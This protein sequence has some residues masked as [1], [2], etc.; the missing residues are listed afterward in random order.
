M[1]EQHYIIETH[2]L[3]CVKCEETILE[4]CSLVYFW[5]QKDRITEQHT[6]SCKGDK[7]KIGE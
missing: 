4:A 2:S 6:A 5:T 3:F 7:L 1:T